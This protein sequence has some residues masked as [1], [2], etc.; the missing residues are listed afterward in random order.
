MFFKLARYILA[1]LICDGL[2]LLLFKIQSDKI[3]MH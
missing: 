3:Y 1:Y 2:S